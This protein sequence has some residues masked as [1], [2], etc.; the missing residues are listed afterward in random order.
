M[1]KDYRIDDDTA[2]QGWSNAWDTSNWA[3]FLAMSDKTVIGV[4]TVA[5]RTEGVHML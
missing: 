3:Y 1:D 5:Y 4:A 2:V